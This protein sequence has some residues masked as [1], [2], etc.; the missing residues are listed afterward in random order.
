MPGNRQFKYILENYFQ[1]EH[2]TRPVSHIYDQT[3]GPVLA[4][5]YTEK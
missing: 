5:A 3:G 1:P 2:L 4:K